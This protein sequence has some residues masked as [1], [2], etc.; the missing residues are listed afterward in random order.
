MSCPHCGANLNVD[1]RSA[2]VVCQYCGTSSR[3]QTRSRVLQIPR[4]LPSAPGPE[5][6]VA[7]Q[8]FRG[9]TPFLASSLFIGAVTLGIGIAAHRSD[10]AIPQA[11]YQQLHRA[12][13]S[14]ER[15]VSPTPASPDTWSTGVPLVTDVD[16]DGA[17]DLI[18][19]TRNVHDGD[20]VQLA[21][22]AGATGAVLWRGERLGTYSAMVQA[23]IF[24]AGELVLV[25][26][27]SGDL[28]AYARAD[29]SPRWRISLGERVAEICAIGAR[30]EAALVGTRDRR[31][32]KVALADGSRATAGAPKRVEPRS[33]SGLALAWVEGRLPA[34]TCLPLATAGRDAMPGLATADSWAR[35]AKI[36]G[37]SVLRLA[38]RGSG[39]V[40]AI[41]HKTPGTPV[42]MLAVLDGRKLRW[43]AVV[44]GSGPL[45]ARAD[46][47]HLTVDES[48][49]FQVWEGKDGPRLAAFALVDG[50]RRW[51]VA[52]HPELARV[53]VGV[54]A[55]GGRVAVAGWG[56]LQ[57]FDV[58]TGAPAYAL[59]R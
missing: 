33:R 26:T 54:V 38:R 45:D 31:W 41:G 5:R 50:R 23:G 14:V 32:H 49:V 21:A 51:E 29:G 47:T 13:A 37:M 16:G 24:L 9:A 20:R 19:L 30:P 22:F 56:G 17:D 6:P 7:R 57:A 40:V 39:P 25:A 8:R 11:A 18:G 28:Q 44:P 1:D 53:V 48:S 4:P 15:V 42:P 43:K 46:D 59:G 2:S 12:I 58:A 55:V 36:E 27:P 10:Q 52:L 34:G 35:L 3:V